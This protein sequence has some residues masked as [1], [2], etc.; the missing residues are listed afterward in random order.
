MSTQFETIITA[1]KKADAEFSVIH[2]TQEDNEAVV[3]EFAITVMKELSGLVSVA[4]GN[5]E[6]INTFVDSIGDEVDRCF[7]SA[8]N[9]IPAD[10][11][12]PRPGMLKLIVLGADMRSGR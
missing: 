4:G 5:P 9:P 12:K 2:G 10:M 8:K 6:Y 11:F 7:Y 3:R 1:A